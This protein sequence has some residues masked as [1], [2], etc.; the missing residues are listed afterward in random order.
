MSTLF[1]KTWNAIRRTATETLG[2]VTATE[3]PFTFIGSIQ[4]E[5]AKDLSL[6]DEARLDEGRV[7]IYTAERLVVGVE[8]GSALGD[9]VIYDEHR[10]EVIQELPFQNGLIPHRKYI[11][12]LRDSA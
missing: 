11:A 5:T 8:G 4:P 7:K 12:T 9:I 3:T 2:E 10:Y 6:R 1:P